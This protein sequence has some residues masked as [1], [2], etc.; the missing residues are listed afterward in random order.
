MLPEIWEPELTAV[1]V[2]MAIDEPSDK[3][4]FHHLHARDRFWEALE[5]GG[6]TPTRMI[7]PQ[8]RKALSEGQARGN[9]S[10]PIR[11]MFIQKKTSHLLRAGVGIT[12]LNRR[13]V[14]SD[15]KDKTA[16]PTDEDLRELFKKVEALKPKILA[17]VINPDTFLDLFKSN[18]PVVS[19]TIGAQAFAIGGSEVWLLGS[20][21]KVLRGEALTAQEDAFFELGERM[22]ALKDAS[23]T[24]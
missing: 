11:V 16:L 4:G 18:Y 10:D 3:L 6:I 2:G 20:T 15:E 17:F 12:V 21:I 22:S 24:R 7:T 23:A 5:L 13:V 14:A 19:G 9:L 1:F 8:E